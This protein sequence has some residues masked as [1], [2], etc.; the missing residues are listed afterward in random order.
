ML[1]NFK[2]GRLSQ[3]KVNFRP[4]SGIVRTSTKSRS[5]KLT[6]GYNIICFLVNMFYSVSA[7]YTLRH[8]LVSFRNRSYMSFMYRRALDSFNILSEAFLHKMGLSRMLGVFYDAWTYWSANV[9]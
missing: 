4:N 1:R 2:A 8:C 3:R 5:I 6:N 7:S 9:L